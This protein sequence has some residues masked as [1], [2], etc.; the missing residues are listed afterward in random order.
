V[1]N[2]AFEIKKFEKA[3]I[4]IKI[5]VIKNRF[6]KNINPELSFVRTLNIKKK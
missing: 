2:K 1:L 6:K 3:K 4:I 5:R